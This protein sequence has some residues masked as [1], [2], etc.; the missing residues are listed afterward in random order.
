[1]IATF[2]RA[3]HDDKTYSM[4]DCISFIVMK[5]QGERVGFVF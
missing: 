1:M 5:E 2:T 3:I 4:T